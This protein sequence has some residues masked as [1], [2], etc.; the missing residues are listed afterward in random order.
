MNNTMSFFYQGAPGAY[1]NAAAEVFASNYAT[2]SQLHS[3]GTFVDVFNHSLA[4]PSNF[5]VLPLEN[6]TIGAIG[7][8]Y[9]LL[10]T[11]K[12]KIIDEVF[13]PVRHCLLGPRGTTLQGI[14]RVYS[15]PAALQQCR[16][17]F[18]THLHMEP[19]DFNDTAGAAELVRNSND[20]SVAAIARAE[21]ASIYNLEIVAAD[22][23]DYPDNE[24]RFV[25]V[26]AAENEIRTRSERGG[27]WKT[28]L[29]FDNVGSSPIPPLCTAQT[30]SPLQQ[31]SGLITSIV[32]RAIPRS[33]WRYAVFVDLL[34]DS[35]DALQSALPLD[36]EQC[37]VLGQYPAYNNDRIIAKPANSILNT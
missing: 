28:T 14:R 27:R 31:S 1:S 33:S 30:E 26:T 4:A 35:V 11:F 16:T 24:T 2:D 17:L 10:R 18:E 5:G 3:C 7:V 25:L 9:D 13:L 22:I 19:V 23:Q 34:W 20:R 32:S 37:R 29:L 8:N 21:A 15:H 36:A 6:S 12:V